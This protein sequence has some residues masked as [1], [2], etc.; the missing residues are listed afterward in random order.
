[1]NNFSGKGKGQFNPHNN[2]AVVNKVA[3]LI[4]PGSDIVMMYAQ[5]PQDALVEAKVASLTGDI[6]PKNIVEGSPSWPSESMIT[7]KLKSYTTQ[8]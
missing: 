8:L 4:E 1:M 7:V 6:A 2:N 3:I 5:A